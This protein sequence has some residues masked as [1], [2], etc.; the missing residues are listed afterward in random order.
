MSQ[1]TDGLLGARGPPG[2]QGPPVSTITAQDNAIPSCLAEYCL[3][4]ILQGVVGLPGLNGK[5][6]EDG[7]IVRQYN[8]DMHDCFELSYDC[9]I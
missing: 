9:N 4:C 6:G 7:P 5:D 8:N 1:G 2:D 3:A